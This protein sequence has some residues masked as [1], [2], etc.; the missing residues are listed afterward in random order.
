MNPLSLCL[1]GRGEWSIYTA[2]LCCLACLL[3]TFQR[4]GEYNILSWEHT[5]LY[6][7]SSNGNV[8]SDNFFSEM[9]QIKAI[10]KSCLESELGRTT[11]HRQPR[12]GC[13]LLFWRGHVR[14]LFLWLLAETGPEC[15]FRQQL[16]S[17]SCFSEHVLCT[18]C[19]SKHLPALSYSALSATSETGRTTMHILRQ[20]RLSENLHT[21]FSDFFF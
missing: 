7:E 17:G 6:K 4:P 11:D 3:S 14:L 9:N 18:G 2:T 13:A 10:K 8:N 5:G 21:S 15:I 12:V 19:L 16:Y 1:R 20:M